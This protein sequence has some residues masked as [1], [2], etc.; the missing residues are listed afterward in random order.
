MRLVTAAQA[1]RMELSVIDIFK[2]PKLSDLAAKV[3]VVDS[4]AQPE[5]GIERFSLL[6]SPLARTHVLNELAE[7]CRIS[8]DS[9]QDAYPLSPLQ[10]AFIALSI[11]QRGAYVA[12]HILVLAP[13]VDLQKFK[14]AWDKT[15]QETDLLRT[16]IAQLQS[17]TFL[18]TVLVEDPISWRETATLKEA[19]EEATSMPEH[20]GGKLA[21]YTIVQTK[22]KKRYFVWTLHHAGKIQNIAHMVNTKS[23]QSTTVG[24]FLSCYNVCSKSTRLE[25]RRYPG[26]LTPSSS[27]TSPIWTPMPLRLI[28]GKT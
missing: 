28:G 13:S 23:K 4:N 16:R 8:K 14:A 9:I 18:Q 21:A 2:T 25:F 3:N 10:E 27:S 11:K 19:E 15:V 12:Q 26:F 6:Q 22:S 1:E 17:G 20:L 24:A 7:Q 5:Q